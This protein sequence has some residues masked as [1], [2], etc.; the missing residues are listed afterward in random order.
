MLVTPKVNKIIPA[1]NDIVI[2]ILAV[3]GTDKPLNFIYNEYKIRE[4]ENIIEIIPTI[5]PK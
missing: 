2:I 1:K 5:I 3:P 4:N